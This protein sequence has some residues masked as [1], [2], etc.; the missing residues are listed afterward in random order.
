MVQTLTVLHLTLHIS[1]VNRT[2]T[3]KQITRSA[4]PLTGQ[5]T[6]PTAAGVAG[7]GGTSY[8]PHGHGEGPETV[9]RR[10]GRREGNRD[11]TV[12]E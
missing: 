4:S 3:G 12:G 6:N 10:G 5:G 9:N 8:H 11:G 7:P 1:P 2:R